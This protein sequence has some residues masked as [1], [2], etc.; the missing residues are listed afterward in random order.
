[1]GDMNA[2]WI[3]GAEAHD[4]LGQLVQGLGLRSYLAP[5]A[6]NTY[7]ARHPWRRI[8]WI[9]VSEDLEFDGY[10]TLDAV[11]SDHRAVVAELRMR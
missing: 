2:S 10:R 8:D 5:D 7:S 1:M 9:L 3:T 6:G 4:A 11:V